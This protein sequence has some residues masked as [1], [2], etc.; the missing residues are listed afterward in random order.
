MRREQK[1]KNAFLALK[2]IVIGLLI[3]IFS[4]ILAPK[5]YQ[6][7]LD[8]MSGNFSISPLWALDPYVGGFLVILGII[9]FGWM[10]FSPKGD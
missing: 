8:E 10:L 7:V 6:S 9:L 2:L 1:V 3:G 5:H 4:R